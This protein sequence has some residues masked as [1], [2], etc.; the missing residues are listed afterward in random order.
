MHGISL[1]STP[2]QFGVEGFQRDGTVQLF[3]TIGQKFLHCPGTTG[4]AKN[5][6]TGRDG[7]AKSWE[8]TGRDNKNPRRDTGK[9]GTEQKRTF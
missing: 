7:T 2:G 5:L 6:A 1:L 3:G 9:N 4:Q 8:R